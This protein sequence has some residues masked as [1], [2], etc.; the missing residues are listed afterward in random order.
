MRPIQPGIV[1]VIVESNDEG[2]VGAV[3]NVEFAYDGPLPADEDRLDGWWIVHPQVPI[4][5]DFALEARPELEAAEAE[6][7]GRALV[8]SSSLLPLLLGPTAESVL[9]WNMKAT[10]H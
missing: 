3:V 1:A 4:F 9:R 2:N 7:E 10:L 8:H 5:G 6:T